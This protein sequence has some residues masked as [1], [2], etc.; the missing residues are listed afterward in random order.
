MI[1][2][3]DSGSPPHGSTTNRTQASA[4]VEPAV[5]TVSALLDDARDLVV[6]YERLLAEVSGA[7]GGSLGRPG[8]V[9]ALDQA[10][11]EARQVAVALAERAARL[12]ER[13]AELRT[14]I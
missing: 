13:I 12:T 5:V 8:V 9:D 1:R 4:L 7:A 3:G 14:A 10:A 2:L 6:R 11:E